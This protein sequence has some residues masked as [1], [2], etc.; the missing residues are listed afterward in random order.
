MRSTP[1]SE[2]YTEDEAENKTR[3]LS[4]VFHT[5]SLSLSHSLTHSVSLSLR[6]YAKQRKKRERCMFSIT[7]QYT[8]SEAKDRVEELKIGGE[9]TVLRV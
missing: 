6:V 2:G 8:L 5:Y 4:T 9:A 7:P 1:V 3:V